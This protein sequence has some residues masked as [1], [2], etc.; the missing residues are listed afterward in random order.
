MGAM[1]RAT[2]V[3]FLGHSTIL[4]EVGGRRLLT[5]PLLR[6]ILGP[7]VRYGPV[8]HPASY[9]DLDAVLI[10]HLHLDH[11]DLASLR[12]IERGPRLIVPKGATALLRHLH[13]HDIV[14][15]LPG[16]VAEVGGV[17]VR[18]TY[19]EHP[20]NRRPGGLTGVA[21]GFMLES[22]GQRIYFAGDTDLFPGMAD[23]DGPDLAFL[24]VSGWGLTRGRGHLDP[25]DAAEALALIRPRVAVPIHW[26]TFWPRGLSAVQPARRSGAG[27]AFARFAAELAPDVHVAVTQPGHRV[28][29]PPHPSSLPSDHPAAGSPSAP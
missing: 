5:D 3:Q 20:G 12:R 15:L 13:H 6:G 29:L 2:H 7:L 19:A 16:D 17:R 21:M 26:G 11:L 24:P 8:P 9:G 22:N 18:A 28:H 1:S 14:E 25:R 23:L 10:S 27:P 4:L